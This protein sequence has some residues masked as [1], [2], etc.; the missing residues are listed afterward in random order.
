MQPH[1]QQCPP[2]ISLRS[3]SN[4]KREKKK[5][6]EP[7]NSLT[8]PPPSFANRRTKKT[9]QSPQSKASHERYVTTPLTSLPQSIQRNRPIKAIAI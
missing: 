1:R 5:D 4:Y 9:I 6:R 2:W 3:R 8:L 7:L